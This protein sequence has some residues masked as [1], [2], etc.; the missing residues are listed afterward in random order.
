MSVARSQPTIS[1]TKIPMSIIIP[2]VVVVGIVLTLIITLTV[3]YQKKYRQKEIEGNRGRVQVTDEEAVVE[4]KLEHHEL[5]VVR[6]HSLAST[7][8]DTG[9]DGATL[10]HSVSLRG[11][12]NP[13]QCQS[14]E[15]ERTCFCA[16]AEETERMEEDSDEL[17]H[18]RGKEH[19]AV[20]RAKYPS[21]VARGM[22]VDGS[23]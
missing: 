7:I 22:Y 20:A 1:K 19:Y 11:T 3:I 16:P 8:E 17:I 23:S 6:V 5:V 10:R 9:S 18:A 21:G 15:E 4:K 14:Q 2:I 12:V 13:A